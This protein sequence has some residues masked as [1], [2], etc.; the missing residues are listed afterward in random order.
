MNLWST[1]NNALFSD[2]LSKLR[3]GIHVD[4][5]SRLSWRADW[6]LA[7][8]ALPL[9]IPRVLPVFCSLEKIA[10][11]LV[12]VLSRVFKF[13]L[14]EVNPKKMEQLDAFFSNPPN[15]ELKRRKTNDDVLYEDRGES[16]NIFK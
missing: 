8:L 10:T 13:V 3:G 4:H 1:L 14:D 9:I 7:E 5:G 11:F 16:E 2:S 12:E 15:F 6:R